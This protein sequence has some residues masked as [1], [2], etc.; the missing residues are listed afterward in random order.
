MNFML[1]IPHREKL[2]AP[3]SNRVQKIRDRGGFSAAC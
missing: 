3:T 1:N 2:S